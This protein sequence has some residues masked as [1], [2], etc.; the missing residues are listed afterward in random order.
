MFEAAKKY[1]D[2]LNS[3]EQSQ[4]DAEIERLKEEM[5][6]LTKPFTEEVAYVGFLERKR[7]VTEY[8]KLRGQLGETSR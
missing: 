6:E 2:A 7:A 4:D 5:D 8:K 1:Y 3:L